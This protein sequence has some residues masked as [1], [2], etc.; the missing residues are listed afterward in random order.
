MPGAHGELVGCIASDMR[1]ELLSLWLLFRD[2]K[3]TFLVLELQSILLWP[4]HLNYDR[5]QQEQLLAEWTWKGNTVFITILSA[6]FPKKKLETFKLSWSFARVFYKDT[7]L[8][9]PPVRDVSCK[10]EWSGSEET[11]QCES[12]TVLVPSPAA[13]CLLPP[14]EWGDTLAHESQGPCAWKGS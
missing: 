5:L 6:S 8:V 4:L 9:H 3:S 7:I 14:T 2:P 12:S 11:N 13:L 10:V 1:P